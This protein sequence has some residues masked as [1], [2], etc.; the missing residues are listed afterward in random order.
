MGIGTNTYNPMRAIF[1][2]FALHDPVSFQTMLAIAAKHKAV[3]CLNQKDTVQSITHKTRAIHLA[4]ERLRSETTQ[5]SDGT[6]YAVG[7][8]AVMEVSDFAF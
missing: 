2:Q 1:Q 8:L 5:H 3:V 7:T 6:I 4:N